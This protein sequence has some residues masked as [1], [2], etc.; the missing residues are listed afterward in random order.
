MVP[1][2]PVPTMPTVLPPIS[3]P[4]RPALVPPART[5]WS[6]AGKKRRQAT[7]RPMASSATHWVEYP[8]ALQTMTPFSLQA[9]RPTWSMPVKA[10]SSS[11]RL[12]AAST[13][14]AG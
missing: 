6:Q 5:A 7:A 12:G 9:L 10:T 11:F 8:A 14:E 13:T 4:R 2:A 1:M 3:R